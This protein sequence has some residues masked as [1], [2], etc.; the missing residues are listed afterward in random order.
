[1]LVDNFVGQWLH[2]RE[3]RN[4]QPSDREFDENLRQ[5]FQQETQMLFAS[6][7]REDRPVLDLLDA[8]YTFLNERLA[9][10]YGI[11]D[12][13]GS[14]MRRVSLPQDSPRR[15]VLG[16]GSILTVTSVG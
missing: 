1:E 8:N 10:H 3:L 5:A 15:G 13:R 4:A 2:L 11:R 9:R 6:I 16:Q 7:V 12:V 14:Y